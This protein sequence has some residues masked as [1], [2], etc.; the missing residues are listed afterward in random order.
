M[1]IVRR[2]KAI[3][4]HAEG[5][6]GRVITDGYP[7][8]VGDTM[9]A[10]MQWLETNA[11][12]LRMWMLREPS[13]YPALCANVLVEPTD[14]SA[15]AGFIIMEQSEYAPMS[16][17]NTICVTTALLETGLLPMTEP[18][19]ELTLETPA[20]LI[21]VTA[22]C[23]A[24]KVTQVALKNV[25]S[26]AVA[27]DVQIDVP[28]LG[29]VEVDI[30]WGGMFFVIADADVLGIDLAASNGSEIAR[31]SEM[32]RVATVEQHPVFHPL[33]PSL[34]GPSISQLSGAASLETASRRNAVTLSVGSLDWDRPDTWTG[35]LDRCPCGTGTSAKMA[36]LHARGQLAVGDEFLH[37]GPL[38]T[39]FLGRVIEET[40]VGGYPA[41]ITEISGQ[42]WITGYSEYVLDDTDPF[43]NGFTVGDIW[44]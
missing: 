18:I 21:G 40:T 29:P 38:D 12:H 26:F 44:A 22:T 1:G 33:E 11:D 7:E 20:G 30:A 5:E 31:V 23:A 15:D 2:V 25:P 28:H 10:K 24:G 37:Q 35:A 17:S 9:L 34:K 3:E 36:V 8:P 32:I 39:T 13:G 6:P 14:P 43:P 4:V 16:G 19:T 41:I 42:G 27:L